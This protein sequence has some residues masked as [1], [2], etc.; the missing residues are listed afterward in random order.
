MR[1]QFNDDSSDDGD[2]RLDEQLVPVN[3]IFWYLRSMLQSDGGIEEDVSHRIRAW[4]V[5]WW[6]ASNILCEEKSQIN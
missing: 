4:W 6:Q 5:K 3:D 2:V 1:C